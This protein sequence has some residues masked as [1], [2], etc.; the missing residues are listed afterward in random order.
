MALKVDGCALSACSILV[1]L[2][3][4]VLPASS[5]SCSINALR[6]C[7]G[8]YLGGSPTPACCSSIVSQAPCFC[9]YA[10]NPNYAVVIYSSTGRRIASSCGLRY[11]KC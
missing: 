4:I 3:G 9:T 11:P 6:P 8:A 5:Q 7:M 1:L 2:L 10:R